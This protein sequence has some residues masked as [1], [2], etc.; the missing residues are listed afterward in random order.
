MKQLMR[1]EVPDE[2]KWKLTDI[3]K[4]ELLE[5]KFKEINGKIPQFE[6][7]RNNLNRENALECLRLESELGYEVEKIYAYAQMKSDEDK[8]IAKYQELYTQAVQLYVALSTAT[9]F[10]NPAFAKLSVKDL[11]EMAEKKEFSN[12]SRYFELIIREKQHILSDKEEELLSGIGSFSGDFGTVFSM[13]DN[14]DVDLGSIVIDGKR[15]KITQGSFS[16]LLRNPDVNI[17]RKAFKNM[18]KGFIEMRNTV[19]AAYIGNVKHTCFLAKVRKYKNSMDM[20]LSA[21]NI[22]FSV[23]DNLLQSVRENTPL[24]HKYISLRKKILGLDKQHMYDIYMPI[25]AEIDKTFDYDEAYNLVLDG[26]APLGSEYS[27]LLL[28]AKRDNWIDVMETK[29]KRSG[30]YSSGV[31]GVHPFVLLNHNGTLHDVFTI[32]HELGHAMHSYYS[33]LTQVYE[34]ADYTIFVAEIASTVNEVLLI[35]HML[36]TAKGKERMFLLSYYIDMIRTTLFRQT[37]FAE[38]EKYSHE[39]FESGEPLSGE[40]LTEYYYGLNK[41]YYGKDIVHDKEIA[42]EWLRI[43]HFYS[44]FY[45]YKYATGITCAIN[46]AN[47]ILKDE[48]TVIKY[49]EFLSAGGSMDSL[50]IIK[51]MGI[52]L[53]TK[54]PFDFAMGEFAEVLKELENISKEG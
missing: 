41:T 3:I 15:Q 20:A 25:V 30:A 53:T 14:V 54:E 9:A 38:F 17:R 1:K 46:I 16:L 26:L 23:Y 8:S 18:Y 11:T 6:Q 48:K 33:N 40:K 31:Y 36:K 32:A 37:M 51:I 21:N 2:K 44:D 29:A 7:F 47:K 10:I 28:R 45:V 43:P 35:K 19:A 13:F 42:Y 4:P 34:K 22:P 39:L 24:I 5:G 27:D 12:F 49:K 52:D 50:D